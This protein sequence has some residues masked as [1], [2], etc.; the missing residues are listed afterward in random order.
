M[1]ELVET[2]DQRATTTQQNRSKLLFSH[3][4][5]NGGKTP[6]ID[7]A[8]LV[9]MI[10][11][12]R[13]SCQAFLTILFLGL[14]AP[15]ATADITLA[16]GPQTTNLS[17]IINGSVSP[18][19]IN[20]TDFGTV[21][22]V[23]GSET[24]NFEIVNQSTKNVVISNFTLTPASPEFLLLGFPSGT[25]TLAPNATQTFT[26]TFS[27]S[28]PGTYKT[29]FSLTADGAPFNF[30]LQGDS[31]PQKIDLSGS[32]DG[33]VYRQI[34]DGDSLPETIDGTD[35]GNISINNTSETNAFRIRNVGGK[36]LV[37]SNASLTGSGAS[38]FTASGTIGTLINGGSG[39]IT[40]PPG[41]NHTFQI[42][43]DPAAVGNFKPTLTLTSNDPGNPSFSFD[44]R[45]SGA[46][47]PDMNI[48]NLDPGVLNLPVTI[49]DD[50][51]TP[52]P[53]TDFG[54]V[55][56]GTTRTFTYRIDNTGDNILFLGIASTGN[57]RYVIS[58]IAPSVAAGAS[59]FFTISYTP[60]ATVRNNATF[61][62]NT[63]DP[64]KNP[65][66]FALTGKGVSK[67]LVVKTRVPST[68]NYVTVP[69]NSSPSLA[70][71]TD[72]GYQQTDEETTYFL[73]LF[74]PGSNDVN[75][76][77]VS[78][79]GPNASDFTFD[80]VILP[81]AI[82]ITN[83]SF[84]LTIPANTSSGKGFALAFDFEAN[85][86]G[87][88]LATV[89][90]ASNDPETP[91]YL[92][93]LR[94]VT[95]DYPTATLQKANLQPFNF[96]FSNAGNGDDIGKSRV[97][98]TIT[99]RYAIKN[100][101]EANLIIQSASFDNPD[102]DIVSL[103]LA[104]VP[105]GDRR[106]F[107]VTF[108]PSSVG[109]IDANLTI[110]SN[111]LP[112]A[113]P[114]AGI[115]TFWFK[116]EGRP[117]NNPGPA[118][119]INAVSTSG[120]PEIPNDAAA[121]ANLGTRFEIFSSINSSPSSRYRITNDGD[122]TLFIEAASF[123]GSSTFS[124]DLPTTFTSIPIL[125]NE[126]LDFWV[127]FSTNQPGIYDETLTILNSVDA[128][129][130]DG[131]F[132]INF[133]G[134]LDASV[135]P[136]IAV[137]NSSGLS[138]INN[139]STVG[140]SGYLLGTNFGTVSLG[141]TSTRQYLIHNTGGSPLVGSLSINS[142]LFTIQG[143]TSFSVAPNN[144]YPVDV[145]FAP[146]NAGN[147]S[148]I[149][150]INNSDTT[151]SEDPYT[152]QITGTGSD[153]LSPD[154]IIRT[155]SG[156]VM[157]DHGPGQTGGSVHNLGTLNLRSS[158]GLTTSFILENQGD[159]PLTINEISQQSGPGS[160]NLFGVS[161][162]LDD[163]FLLGAG[164][165]LTM[166]AN[167]FSP[168]DGTFSTVITVV[169]DDPDTPVYDFTL[170]A[171]TIGEDAPDPEIT[172]FTITPSATT[173]E[174]TSHLNKHYRVLQSTDLINW[175]PVQNLQVLPGTNLPLTQSFPNTEPKM[176]FRIEQE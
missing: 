23:G 156:I 150:T 121:S 125:P 167:F 139:G 116:G 137:T 45:G 149:L 76:S 93:N 103:N 113:D 102:F 10:C 75:V 107:D 60:S 109:Q 61:S 66:N 70:T 4:T 63:G 147:V 58:D 39:S 50:K 90:I 114:T 16:G 155:A 54:N 30:M 163:P 24:S 106:E 44:L 25:I 17:P 127:T 145:T 166:N 21:D 138:E 13:N 130:E 86:N 134:V 82:N 133:R 170:Q 51:T 40:I 148:A 69:H 89:N 100:N 97:G 27:P 136:E 48:V 64:N 47:F 20:G 84:P 55:A 94:V 171:L 129:V 3:Q 19:P 28:A 141:Q 43:F 11:R 119:R 120:S 92:V 46:G 142:S 87:T 8:I 99:K 115:A 140:R 72:L 34:A 112:T 88:K 57:G 78:I 174:F 118:I 108:R 35:F 80:G 169:S 26:I 38:N 160:A 168:V 153:S 59:T 105:P 126:Y 135:G 62:I 77:S 101:G 176:F 9:D 122:E 49:P 96:G 79:T 36:N 117:N 132:K 104:P 71:N 81:T 151:D 73:N 65:Y 172:S 32:P 7:S 83:A 158:S 42:T 144:S 14:L 159:S 173:L 67:E 56:V 95:G 68:F 152:F 1:P 2:H 123:G 146:I 22:S 128:P 154:L 52:G 165:S 143:S 15:L 5:N 33:I 29:T 74:N 175:T 124:S 161:P 37:V 162:N 98:Q 131:A 31:I 91:N 85:S 41:D 157:S 6:E 164:E 18:I 12:M 53:G 110:E 111:A